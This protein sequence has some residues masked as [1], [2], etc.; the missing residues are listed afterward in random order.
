[1]KDTRPHSGCG[2]RCRRFQPAVG[3]TRGQYHTLKGVALG[4]METQLY[5]VWFSSRQRKWLL[6]GDV[7][8]AIQSLLMKVAKDKG[9]KVLA[10]GMMADHVHLLLELGQ[11]QDL[12]KAVNLLKGVTARQVFQQ[13]PDLRM[14]AGVEH[15]W[16]KRYG[17]KLV[18]RGAV[19]SVV[20]Y[21]NSQRDRPDE[22]DRP[23]RQPD[24]APFRVR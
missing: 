24:A 19:E 17:Y 14:D 8:E 18:P 9:I 21:I 20:N 6:Q 13:F 23:P 12:G 16:Q 1:V 15:F 4:T 22:L 7:E 2:R 3:H 5:H 11:E 10:L